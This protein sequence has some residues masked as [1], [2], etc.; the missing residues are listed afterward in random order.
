VTSVSK[1]V[2]I[3]GAAKGIG[4]A[5]ALGMA[6][7]GYDVAVNDLPGEQVALEELAGVIKGR[8][9]AAL[10]VPADIRSKEQVT[11]MVGRVLAAWQHVDVLVNNAGILTI[12]SVEDLPQETWERVFDVN[13]MGTF[14]VTQALIPHLKSRRAGRIIHIASI[15]GK[16]GAPG[17]AH[18]CSSK[19]AIIEFTRVLAMELGEYGITVNAVCPGIIL[20]E[21]GRNNLGT[22]ESIDRWT[23]AT[24]LKRLGEPED[25][26]GSVAFFASDDS[27]YITGQSLNVCGGIIYY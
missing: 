1:T 16:L 22:Q 19:A 20:T 18:Y 27:A 26:V 7:R 25:V 24:A 17:Q 14:L 21:M 6:D 9:R 3:T 5:L 11:E 15:G 8:G 13:A 4:R 12:S 2:L 10:V 23:N